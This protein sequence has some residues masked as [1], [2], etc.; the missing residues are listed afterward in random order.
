LGEILDKQRKKD[1]DAMYEFIHYIAN[2]YI[3]L[4]HEKVRIQRDDYVRMARDLIR[5]MSDES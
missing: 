1:Y 3:E 5:R 4:S 2:D